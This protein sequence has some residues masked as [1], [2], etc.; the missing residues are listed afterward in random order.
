M[1]LYEGNAEE[2]VRNFSL[3]DIT[4]HKDWKNSDGSDISE[5]ELKDLTAEVTLKRTISK[6]QSKNLTI[7]FKLR[8]NNIEMDMGRLDT[9]VSTINGTRL[10]FSPNWL[11][12]TIDGVEKLHG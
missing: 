3:T 10:T 8:D 4:V 6:R 5:S 12:L 7:L 1:N 9:P 2:T 11:T